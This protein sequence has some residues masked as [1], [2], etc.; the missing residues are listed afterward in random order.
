L[1][2]PWGLSRQVHSDHMYAN[3]L[4]RLDQSIC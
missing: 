2:T 1:S 4:A 3:A